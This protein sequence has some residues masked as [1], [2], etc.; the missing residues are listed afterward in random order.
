MFTTALTGNALVSFT[1][2]AIQHVIIRAAGRTRNA[3]KQSSTSRVS[4]G[5]EECTRP[6]TP[7]GWR[8]FLLCALLAASGLCAQTAGPS[9]AAPIENG[10]PRL[11][12]GHPCT[13]WDNQDVAAYKIFITSNLGLKAAFGELQA[14]GNKRITEPLNIPAYKLEADGTWSFP[15]YKRGFQDAAGKWNWEWDFNT[16]LQQRAE[17]VSKLGMLYAL[18][19][20]EKAAAFARQ[21]LLALA[22]SYGHGKGSA[23]P[24][25][26]GY[27]HFE[28]YGFDGGDIGM[29]L[30]KACH[31]YDLIYNL[32]SLSAGD[33][34]HIERDLIRPLAEHLKNFTFMYTSHG[35]WGM[36]CLYGLFVAGVTL[37]DQALVDLALYG[38][39]GTKDHVTGGFMDCFKPAC[40]RDGSIWGADTKIEEQMAAVCV[41]T[42]VA[43]V[44]WHHG[45]DLY[46]YQ[47]RAIKKSY[48]AALESAGNG[49]VSK[50]LSLPGIDA[51][52]YVFRRY[53][54]PRFLPVV[55]QLKP[56][57]TLAI[58]EHLPS[59]PAAA[60]TV[61]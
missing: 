28:A 25:S 48:D 5:S 8:V 53:G 9:P 36:V 19:G 29:F 1:M 4:R 52:Q 49:G 44:M 56:G 21:I 31:G 39:E 26:H 27:D 59:L 38:P 24:D 13:L 33:R 14:W 37:N 50:L 16:T 17:D 60:A 55:G 30:A 57:F 43:E 46:G 54:E 12:A 23:I 42:T 35:R 10:S 41:L 51:Y 32:P 6:W 47:D 20:D 22:D 15:A 11:A 58:S 7:A 18:T 34:T 2:K 40:L 3:E 61:K 45:E